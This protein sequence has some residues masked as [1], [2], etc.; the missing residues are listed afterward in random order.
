MSKGQRYRECSIVAQQLALC[1]YEPV[2]SERAWTSIL[3]RGWGRQGVMGRQGVIVRRWHGGDRWPFG[4]AAWPAS[5]RGPAA[6]GSWCWSMANSRQTAAKPS[7]SRQVLPAAGLHPAL[8]CAFRAVHCNFGSNMVRS[9]RH[10]PSAADVQPM[11]AFPP[12]RAVPPPLP[13]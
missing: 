10:A 13:H 9:M 7:T 3:A 12:P 6:A 2:A 8:S 5:S 1:I 4:L 11:A